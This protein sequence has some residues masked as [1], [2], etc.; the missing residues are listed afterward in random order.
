MPPTLYNTP[1]KTIQSQTRK[2]VANE[3][4]SGETIKVLHDVK[5]DDNMP[6]HISLLLLSL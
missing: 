2:V 6:Q 5:S 3:K 4:H 1:N